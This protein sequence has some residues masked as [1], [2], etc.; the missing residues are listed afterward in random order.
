[1]VTI[2]DK[3]EQF[4]RDCKSNDYYTKMVLDCN[5]RLEEIAVKLQGISS[6]AVKDVICENANDPY[7]DNKLYWI[8][9]E[10]K[11]LKEREDYISRINNVNRMLM[12]ILDPVDRQMVMD[13]YI[14]KRNHESIADKYHYAN[15]MALYKHIN[16]V[17]E[18][19]V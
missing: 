5:E 1:M 16:K 14:M 7:K 10:E 2:K 6:P 12:K 15:R 19:I 13:L 11:V 8:Y 3:V 9:Q 18:K 17:I 4:K